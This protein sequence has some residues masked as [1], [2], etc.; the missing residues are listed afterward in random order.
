M[1]KKANPT[2]LGV[3]IFL[4]L[5]LGV[6]GL[7][8]FTSSKLFSSSTYFITYFDTSLN[9]LKEGAPVKYRGVTIGSVYRVMIR[10]NQATNDGSMPVVCE[11]R[12]DLI[13][14]RLVG[15]TPFQGIA[16]ITNE[17]SKGLRATL[18]TESI[19][20]GVLF[21][22]LEVAESPSP[23][24]FH[25]LEKVYREVPSRPTQ[26]QQFMKNLAS[27]DIAGLEK[28]LNDL[29]D[30]LDRGLSDLKLAEIA[31]GVTNFLASANQVVRSPDLTN[32]FASLKTTLDQYRLVGEKVAVALDEASRTLTQTRSGVQNLRDLLAP[33]S[34]LR[35]DLTL[36][37]DQLAEA[38][39]S[40]AALADFL[41]SHP[42]AL[43]TGRKANPEKP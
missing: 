2:T 33:D 7:L 29:I 28:N 26:I 31:D 32:S 39:R 42:N 40:V 19:V 14:E 1:S 8:L 3:F 43:L 34:P 22:N 23:P 17:V 4:G 15:M 21:V 27:M 13:R 5:L 6:G 20:T 12:E 36:A 24:V 35:N 18:E 25:Q 30:K 10:F 9:G 41:H 37:L 11:I 16:S 38:S